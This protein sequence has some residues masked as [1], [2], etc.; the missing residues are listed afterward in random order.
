MNATTTLNSSVAGQMPFSVS[1]VNTG[2]AGGTASAYTIYEIRDDKGDIIQ[3][4]TLEI[5]SIKD[6]KPVLQLAGGAASVTIPGSTDVITYQDGVLRIEAA[7]GR[8][9]WNANILSGAEYSSFKLEDKRA[10]T[11]ITYDLI[12]EFDEGNITNSKMPAVL[13]LYD[14][15]A[16]PTRIELEIPMNNDGTFNIP[17]NGINIADILAA[18]SSITDFPPP[19]DTP[20]NAIIKPASEGY[21]FQ[22]LAVKDSSLD[23]SVVNMVIQDMTAVYSTKNDIYDCQGIAR[24]LEVVYKKVGDNIWQWEAFFPKEPDLIIDPK[25]GFIEFG[26]CG[27]LITPESVEISIPYSVTG[28]KDG[29]VTLDFS[30]KS[31]GYDSI[32]G[33]TQFGS[34]NTTK[35][36][37]QDGYAM[38][39]M[40]DFSVAQNGVIYG[41]YTNGKTIPLYR[42]ALATFANPAGLERIGD[43]AFR[44]SANSGMAQ[45]GAPTEGG[46]GITVGGN[47]EMSNVDIAEEFTNLILAQRGFQ[48]NARIVTVSDSMLEELVN[49]KR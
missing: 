48:A 27:K 10:A 26:P 37:F 25:T 7:N 35:A 38:G 4:V 36:Y 5:A 33:I 28:A 43:T 17:Q 45:I 39:V 40:N 24:T 30:G 3:T 8:V 2:T 23:Y 21:G 49:L 18:S 14:G 12:L 1:I 46:A 19:W 6:G 11:T 13:W 9:S 32:E 16:V 15:A 42:L 20:G 31:F 44:E 22:I 29:K 47:L 34:P 41:V